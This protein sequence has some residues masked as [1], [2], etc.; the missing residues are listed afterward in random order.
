MNDKLNM[1]NF[2]ALL[3]ERHGMSRK[4]AENF[5]KEFFQLIEESLGSDKYVKI[6]GL[7]T[8]KLIEVESRES[9]NVNTGERFMIEGHTKV[10]FTPEQTVKDLINKPFEHF[11]TVVLNEETVLKDTPLEGTD[12]PD[13]IQDDVVQEDSEEYIRKSI[14]ENAQGDQIGVEDHL[15]KDTQENAQIGLRESALDDTQDEIQRETLEDDIP[16]DE[17]HGVVQDAQEDIPTDLQTG[18]QDV[19]AA[20]PS[21]AENIQATDQEGAEKELQENTRKEDEVID[22]AKASGETI[23]LVGKEEVGTFRNPVAGDNGQHN[24]EVRLDKQV[25]EEPDNGDLS[26]TSGLSAEKIPGR[27][28]D[29]LGGGEY[30]PKERAEDTRDNS[31]ILSEF[32][33][34]IEAESVGKG[35][36]LATKPSLEHSSVDAS[37]ASTM[38][39]FIGIV[40]FIILLC[41]GAVV[42]MYYPDAFDFISPKSSKENVT[43]QQIN[44]PEVSKSP[45]LL[46]SITRKDTVAP[47]VKDTVAEQVAI[48]KPN[49]SGETFVNQPIPVK[50]KTVDNKKAVSVPFSPDSTNYKIV[51]TKTTYTIKEGETLTRVALHFYGT[52]ALWPYI[53]KHNPEVIKNPDNV[54][55]GTTIKIPELVAK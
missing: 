45:V 36:T 35:E 29:R 40:A 7:G 25:V 13:D 20:I 43:D 41:G 10:S 27:D 51:G 9:V 48:M 38:K 12:I 31:D 37:D 34:K 46:D 54:P 42:Y 33:S 17:H 47:T 21:D 4:N 8:F 22:L 5:V 28:E 53:V 11:D 1:Q 55:Y 2:I 44:K 24:K 39:Y 3:A 14:Q 19:R 15:L 26:I 23:M 30:V 18:M 49:K 6:K 16:V 32:I 52:K 50:P